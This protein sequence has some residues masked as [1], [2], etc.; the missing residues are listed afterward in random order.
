MYEFRQTYN[1]H[2]SS[3]IATHNTFTD[4]LV[5][6]TVPE[7]YYDIIACL[8]MHAINLKK[9]L[10]GQPGTIYKQLLVSIGK[11]CN[12]SSCLSTPQLLLNDRHFVG[13]TSIHN[14]PLYMCVC[15]CVCALNSL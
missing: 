10:E 9:D 5:Y 14:P 13:I 11:V 4:L 6:I 12:T 8:N 2:S 3:I 15:V 7:G 1:S